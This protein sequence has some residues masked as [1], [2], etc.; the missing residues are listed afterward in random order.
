MRVEDLMT[1]DPLTARP[2]TSLKEAAPLFYEHGI[3]GL[4]VVEDG[5]VVGVLSESD[6]VAKETSGYRDGD[7]APEEATHLRRERA[8][9]TVEDAMTSDPVTIEPWVSIW[10]AADLMVARDVNRLPVVDHTGALVG[11][12]TRDDLVRAFARSDRDVEHD[13]REHLLPSVGLTPD[14]LD[15]EVEKGV[16]SVTGTI[17]SEMARDCLRATIHLIPGVVQVD[18]HVEPVLVVA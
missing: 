14:A 11:I 4:P 8:A 6:I 15:I 18:W 5:K 9:I 3:S 16:V 10:G 13:I 7:V 17:D 2:S 1:R 12:V